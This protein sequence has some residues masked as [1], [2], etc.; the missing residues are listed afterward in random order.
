MRILYKSQLEFLLEYCQNILY[1][2]SQFAEEEAFN[3]FALEMGL[4]NIRIYL[5][6]L[7]DTIN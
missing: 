7:H 3:N 4:K 6:D 5:E 2:I 1:M